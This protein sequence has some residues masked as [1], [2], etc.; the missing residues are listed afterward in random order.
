MS[1]NSSQTFIEVNERKLVG[2]QI[3]LNDCVLCSFF[4]FALN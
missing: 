2:E 1:H 3:A 4:M